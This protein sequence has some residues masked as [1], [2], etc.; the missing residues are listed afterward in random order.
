MLFRSDGTPYYNNNGTTGWTAVGSGGGGV[1]AIADTSTA[2][3]LYPLFSAAQTGAI[4]NVYTSN[5]NLNF[6]PSTGELAADVLN[7]TNGL[8]VN[9]MTV[10]ASYSIASGS[11]AM[12]VGPVTVASGVSVTV[13]S[14]SRW[15]VL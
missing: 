1:T 10:S 3:P 13:P 4:T 7:A 14:G 9:N 8:V 6:T 15:V 2:T 5:G 11:S 12:S